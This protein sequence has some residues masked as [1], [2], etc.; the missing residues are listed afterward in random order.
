M[1]IDGVFAAQDYDPD[2]F[3]P[4]ATPRVPDSGVELA[5][6]NAILEQ[7]LRIL[8]PDGAPVGWDL[9]QA[10]EDEGYDV[11]LGQ[12]IASMTRYNTTPIDPLDDAYQFNRGVTGGGSPPNANTP[13]IAKL[14]VRP[15]QA[16]VRKVDPNFVGY[17]F[18]TYLAAKSIVASPKGNAKRKAHTQLTDVVEFTISASEGVGKALEWQAS[19]DLPPEAY[20]EGLWLS[21]PVPEGETPD[22]STIRLQSIRKK[23]PR[24][25]TTRGPLKLGSHARKPPKFNE[26]KVGKPKKLKWGQDLRIRGGLGHDLQ[27]MRLKAGIVVTTAQGETEL[28]DLT[29]PITVAKERPGHGVVFDPKHLHPAASGFKIFVQVDDVDNPPWYQIIRTEKGNKFKRFARRN[30][31]VLFGYKDTGEGKVSDPL[32]PAEPDPKHGSTELANS[33][34]ASANTM[35]VKAN[36]SF[37][38]S[39]G[40]FAKIDKEIVYITGGANTNTWNIQRGAVGTQPASHNADAK[41]IEDFTLEKRR[42][43]NKHENRHFWLLAPADPP[44]EDSTGIENP[45]GEIDPP[46]PVGLGRPGPG[47]WYVSYGRRFDGK[48]TQTAPPR[49]IT[50]AA[51]EVIELRFPPRVNRINNALYG[52]LNQKGIPTNW[53]FTKGDTTAYTA[54]DGDI[55]VLPGKVHLKTSGTLVANDRYPRAVSWDTADVLGTVQNAG[56]GADRIRLTLEVSEYTSG[57]AFV[58]VVQFNDAGTALGQALTLATLDQVGFTYVDTTIGPSTAVAADGGP[59][60]VLLDQNATYIGIRWGIENVNNARNLKA[61]VY[62]IFWHP[63]DAHPRR[64]EERSRPDELWEPSNDPADP[65]PGSHVI[66]I[67]KAPDTAGDSISAPAPMNSVFHNNGSVGVG[68]I[69]GLLPSGF[70]VVETNP[71]LNSEATIANTSNFGGGSQPAAKFRSDGH[72]ALNHNYFHKNYTSTWPGGNSLALRFKLYIE[73]LPTKANRSVQVAAITADDG[74][75]MAWFQLWR[76]GTLELHTYNYEYYER[77]AV[78]QRNLQNEDELDLEVIVGGGNTNAG[79]A[80]TYI[81]VNGRARSAGAYISGVDWDPP[82]GTRTPRRVMYGGFQENQPDQSWTFWFD[83]V[84]ITQNGYAGTLGGTVVGPT[85]MPDRPQRGA[86]DYRDT[87][88]D[89][90]TIN[91]GYAFY[92]RSDVLE[93]V[94]MGHETDEF[95]VRPGQQRTAAVFMKLQDFPAGQRI[96]VLAAYNETGDRVELGCLSEQT[97]ANAVAN[98]TP[99]WFEFWM[100]YTPPEGYFRLRWEHEGTTGGTYVWQEPVDAVGFLDTLAE[101]DAARVEARATTAT[102][103]MILEARVPGQDG[104]AM[105]NGWKEQRKAILVTSQIPDE[106]QALDPPAVTW[107]ARSSDRTDVWLP[108]QTDEDLIPDLKYVD[109][110]ITLRGDGTYTPIVP[111]GGVSVL[112]STYQPILLRENRTA[113]WGGVLIGGDSDSNLPRRTNRHEY[114]TDA[115]GGQAL[116]RAMTDRIGRL[117]PYAA[118]VYTREA[119]D[120]LA[121]NMAAID[122]NGIADLA[123][124]FIEDWFENYYHRIRFYAPGDFEEEIDYDFLERRQEELTGLRIPRQMEIEATQVMET[125]FLEFIP[126]GAIS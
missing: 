121:D 98:L 58:E 62:N 63:F 1:P 83:D 46:I 76:D 114:D 5:R 79:I 37:P 56:T 111:A 52:Q 60:D 105:Q 50:I 86:G 7:W 38:S 70:A 44:T 69:G 99:G 102:F 33:L 43:L 55:E 12:T 67:S 113:L 124:W 14:A 82:S 71:G 64:F 21:E 8:E 15:E 49:K 2:L 48:P 51:D 45:D 68:S 25:Y 24:T 59:P 94:E 123:E 22:A 84:V 92:L 72:S 26:T 80:T 28:S 41:V 126:N 36:A 100:A 39:A 11:Y 91:Q 16:S 95:Y 104:T 125:H 29:D 117:G 106:L 34:S 61:A 19:Q 27:P 54:K 90:A 109:V 73:R 66:A 53:T 103:R 107:R 40:Y 108:Y 97:G 118:R 74:S 115:V 112:Y 88:P 4:G 9:K 93:N 18:G 42:E 122:L 77:S 23:G 110:E 10:P 116:P 87:A 85:P 120:E 75:P 65:V 96:F 13:D 32:M 78:V 119:E 30:K 20:G 35:T 57:R 47:T 31:P 3:D 6:T 81:S 17:P 101:R 89:G